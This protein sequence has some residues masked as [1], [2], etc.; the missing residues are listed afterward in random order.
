MGDIG[1][2]D[3]GEID[4]EICSIENFADALTVLIFY[5]IVVMCPRFLDQSYELSCCVQNFF[6]FLLF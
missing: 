6:F 4:E 5:C 2:P 3:D 1:A